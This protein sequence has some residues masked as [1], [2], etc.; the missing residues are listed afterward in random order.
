MNNARGM[1]NGWRI[2]YILADHRL[3]VKNAA[4][5]TDFFGSDHCPVSAIV[6]LPQ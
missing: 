6:E 2:D 1:N 4:I 5:H 3:K